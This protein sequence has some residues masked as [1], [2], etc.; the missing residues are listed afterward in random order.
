M[1][2]KGTNGCLD[3]GLRVARRDYALREEITAPMIP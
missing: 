1:P 2:R 3:P